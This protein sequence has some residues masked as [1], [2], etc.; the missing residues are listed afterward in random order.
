MNQ[1]VFINI[2]FLMPFILKQNLHF[3][4]SRCSLFLVKRWASTSNLWSLITNLFSA[5]V[6][7]QDHDK[8]T[9]SAA[10][11]AG[12]TCIKKEY[13]D[14]GLSKWIRISC[15]QYMSTRLS[16]CAACENIAFLSQ[17]C[18]EDALSLVEIKP[19]FT[20][21]LSMSLIH[22]LLSSLKSTHEESKAIFSKRVSSNPL[23]FVQNP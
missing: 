14:V 21:T 10:P 2:Y 3:R 1:N 20:N 12:W 8:P 15:S 5:L 11:K 23:V 4:N 7:A 6:V 18:S 22:P 17:P 9:T 13:F 16:K 19:T